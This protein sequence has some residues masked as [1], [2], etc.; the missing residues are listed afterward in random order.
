[1]SLDQFI[2]KLEEIREREG[3]ELEVWTRSKPMMDG[4]WDATPSVYSKK[5]GIS[6]NSKVLYDGTYWDDVYN[7]QGDPV[8]VIW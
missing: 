2:Q 8:V 6:T 4:Y 3:G 7:I 1:M 5:G